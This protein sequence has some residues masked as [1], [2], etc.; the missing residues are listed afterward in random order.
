MRRSPSWQ[1]WRTA[2]APVW[3]STSI[4]RCST[5]RWRVL[6]TRSAAAWLAALEP[7]GVPCAPI[8][9]VAEVF[10]DPQVRHRGLRVEVP[11]PVAGT[12]PLVANP[13]RLSGAPI[14]YDAP[15]PLLGQHTEE[16]LRE[17]LGLTATAIA[18]LRRRGVV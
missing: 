10:S 7:V 9:D 4:W 16:I 14:P 13:I 15:P 11:H 1:R 6:A 5:C 8:N 12:V 2:S 18:D 17:R 3:G